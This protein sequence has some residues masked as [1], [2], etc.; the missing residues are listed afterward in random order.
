MGLLL[1]AA[2]LRICE[3]V[4]LASFL[5]EDRDS[6]LTAAGVQSTEVTC[7]KIYIKWGSQSKIEV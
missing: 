2:G 7:L 1:S 3:G 4:L 5:G 6:D